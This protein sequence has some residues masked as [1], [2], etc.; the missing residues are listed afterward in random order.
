MAAVFVSV[1]GA[2][3]PSLAQDNVVAGNLIGTDAT[4]QLD[5][6]NIGPGVRVSGMNNTIG[7]STAAHGNVISGNDHMGLWITG[8]SGNTASFNKVG[9]DVDGNPDLGNASHGIWVVFDSPDNVIEFNTVA[10]NGANG[11]QVE[12]AGST[13]N[14]IRQNEIFANGFLGIDLACCSVTAN[15]EDDPDL[16]ANNFQNFPELSD[17]KAR[18]TH[19]V[20]EGTLNSTP[21]TS[22]VLEF[23]SNGSCDTSGNGEGEDFIFTRSIMTNSNGDATFSYTPPST[24]AP[25]FFL[26]ATA[27]NDGTGDTSEFSACEEAVAGSP[28]KKMCRG[29]TADIVGTNASETINGTPVND[30]IVGLG[31]DDI[32]NG[33][34]GNDTICGNTGDDEINGGNDNDTLIGGMDDDTL[35]GGFG[36]DEILGRP[37][38]DDLFGNN[39]VDLLGG[40]RGQDD[41]S[42]GPDGPDDCRGGTGG[43]N[44]EAD[45]AK[46]SCELTQG[47]P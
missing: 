39:G 21:S 41:L 18:G 40:G 22:F 2:N 28:P 5:V 34:G 26:T 46:P 8:G 30:V 47:I 31:G 45:T 38:D 6:G 43:P 23:F 24:M 3:S 12:G 19:L 11:I 25:G 15:D 1:S 14:R 7:G 10:D 27:T 16:G 29:Q 36:E 33:R 20:V 9:T 32:I 35:K 17:V 44:P 4:G 37:G 42:G 13:G